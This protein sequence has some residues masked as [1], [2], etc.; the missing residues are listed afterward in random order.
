[1][2]ID[3]FKVIDNYIIGYRTKTSPF[4]GNNEYIS[5][6]YYAPYFSTCPYTSCHPGLYL[7]PSKQQVI[8]Y[9]DCSIKEVIKVKAYIKDVH[10]AGDKWRCKKFFIYEY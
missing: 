2:K 1:M 10:K 6:W 9:C 4:I 5:G 8:N 7:F 3:G